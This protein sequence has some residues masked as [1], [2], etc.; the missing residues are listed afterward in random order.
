MHYLLRLLLASCLSAWV[1]SCNARAQSADPPAAKTG[2]PPVASAPPEAGAV[3]GTPGETGPIVARVNGEPIYASEV[4]AGL[5]KPSLF[6]PNADRLRE[7]K[8][9]RL[10]RARVLQQFLKAQRIEVT[11]AVIDT[12]VEQLRKTPPSAGCAC[13]RY[14][15]I[16]EFMQS[17]GIDMQ[18]LRTGIANDLGTDRYLTA[19][20]EKEYPAGEKREALLRTER[21]R[22]EREYVKASHI[23]FNTF[24]D[25][26][27]ADDP[28]SVRRE[29]GARAEAAWGRLQKG[30]AFETVA[31]AVSEDS[32]SKLKGGALGC[33]PRDAFGKQFATAI[34]A[35]KPGQYGKPV[36]SPWGWHIVRRE[37]LT[38]AEVLDLLKNDYI[39]RWW[40]EERQH[41]QEQA[42]VERTDGGR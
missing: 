26:K 22:L 42:K 20:W 12:E 25:P 16:E 28:D 23:F 17:L 2:Q 5:P 41:V 36:E 18:E 33:I 21:P 14:S 34:E 38:D 13:C 40:E 35:L 39:N 11:A 15:S 31:G 27:F 8:L 24:Q 7:A 29:A 9:D 30:D 4:E 37:S 3:A 6:E 32:L 10:I 1:W 19:R